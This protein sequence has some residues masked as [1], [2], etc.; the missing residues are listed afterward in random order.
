VIRSDRG[1]RLN[2]TFTIHEE[3]WNYGFPQEIQ[4]VVDCL[5]NHTAPVCTGRDGRAVMEILFAAYAGAREG[6]RIDLPYQP[7]ADTCH[8]EWT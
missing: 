3:A 2:W 6:R 1:R 7:T 8:Q 5:H 4:H